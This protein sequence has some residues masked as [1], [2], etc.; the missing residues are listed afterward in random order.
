MNRP[1]HVTALGWTVAIL[2]AGLGFVLAWVS[3]GTPVAL[4]LTAPLLLTVAVWSDGGH[5]ER[6]DQ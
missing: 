6:G 1:A 2:L 5:V 3:P 4:V